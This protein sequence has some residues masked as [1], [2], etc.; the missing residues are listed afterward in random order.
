MKR[1]LYML[2]NHMDVFLTKKKCLKK[3]NK[4]IKGNFVT[5]K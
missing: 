4:K 2:K 1:I 5:K 3:T